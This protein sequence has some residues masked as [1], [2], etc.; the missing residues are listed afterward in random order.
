MPGS[1]LEETLEAAGYAKVIVTLDSRAVAAA[2][3][4]AGAAADAAAGAA[5]V[6]AAGKGAKG[7]KAAKAGAMVSLRAAV[8]TIAADIENHFIIPSAAQSASL[9]LAARAA[10][11]RAAT[12]RASPA[13]RVRVYPHLKLALG[14]ADKSGV[15][16][17]E[18]HTAVAKVE[19]APS[20]EG[21]RMTAM[22]APK[23][24]KA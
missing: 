3:A 18:A 4:T 6:A 14:F 5:A 16:A 17:L 22:L 12:R 15:A 7:A 2:T 20:M 9:A 10:T 23:T 19:K 1:I 24:A 21:K 8:R 13:P 11:G